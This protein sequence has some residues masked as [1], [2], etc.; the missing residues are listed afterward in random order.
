MDPT[1]GRGQMQ[2]VTGVDLAA[3]DVIG[4]NFRP[5]T[6]T[7]GNY[8]YTTA[9][10]YNSFIAGVPEPSV[11]MQLILG[12]GVIGGAIRYRRRRGVASFV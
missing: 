8:R 10:A 11:W 4:W 1:S 6:S 5:D 3:F 12:F 9:A 2:E 7:F